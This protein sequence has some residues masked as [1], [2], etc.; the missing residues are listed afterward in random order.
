MCLWTLLQWIGRPKSWNVP[1]VI[2]SP[3]KTIGENLKSNHLLVHYKKREVR[4][5]ALPTKLTM[6]TTGFES[7]QCS[8]TMRNPP[9]FRKSIFE[10]QEE[11]K[12]FL[13]SRPNFS[14]RDFFL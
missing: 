11:R 14:L 7:S 12:T 8:D 5:R 10:L 4:A 9:I 6:L 1:S 2:P 13:N 3:M